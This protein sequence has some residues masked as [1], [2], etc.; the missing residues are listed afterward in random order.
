MPIPQDIIQEGINKIFGQTQR[1]DPEIIPLKD[2]K[3]QGILDGLIHM[4]GK[5]P[6]FFQGI[7]TEARDLKKG[8]N[9]KKIG[10]ITVS[11]ITLDVI[12]GTALLQ[13]LSDEEKGKVESELDNLGFNSK[14]PPEWF[15]DAA[16]EDSPGLTD[17]DIENLWEE[18]RIEVLESEAEE[19]I[20]EPFETS[21][22]ELEVESTPEPEIV[23][24]EPLI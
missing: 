18:A 14:I 8:E 1:E 2:A 21:I 3:E 17:S 9:V 16:E 12:E 15:V 13:D 7:V 4:G 22:P 19:Q 5:L 10:N 11:D 6:D 24:E 20:E 23:P